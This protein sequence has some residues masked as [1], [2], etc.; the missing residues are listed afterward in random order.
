MIFD[1]RA[2]VYPNAMSREI[3]AIWTDQNDKVLFQP[4]V[5]TRSGPKPLSW[6]RYC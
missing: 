5:D 3:R 2:A 4:Y 1:K 6:E